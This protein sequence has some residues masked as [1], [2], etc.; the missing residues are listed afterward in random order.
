MFGAAY[1]D[2]R[3]YRLGCVCH[4]HRTRHGFN[5]IFSDMIYGLGILWFEYHADAEFVATKPCDNAARRNN[6]THPVSH[7]AK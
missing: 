5:E 2:G 1:S 7:F 6:F 3:G 4:W